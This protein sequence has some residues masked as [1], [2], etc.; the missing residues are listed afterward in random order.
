VPPAD[1]PGGGGGPGRADGGGEVAL[2]ALTAPTPYGPQAVVTRGGLVVQDGT[3]GQKSPSS[4]VDKM[5]STEYTSPESK[6]SGGKPMSS[7]AT[8][9]GPGVHKIPVQTRLDTDDRGQGVIVRKT[10]VT[11]VPKVGTWYRGAVVAAVDKKG[12]T[13]H[14]TTREPTPVEQLAAKAADINAEI[15]SE[16]NRGRAPGKE[17]LDLP[18]LQAKHDLDAAKLRARGASAD[19]VAK[20]GAKRPVAVPRLELARQPAAPWMPAGGFV[21][22]IGAAGDSAIVHSEGYDP[23]TIPLASLR[24]VAAGGSN[25]WVQMSREDAQRGVDHFAGLPSGGAA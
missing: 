22:V 14:V 24:T 9:T 16:Q 13:Y 18:L 21:S 25:P 20:H 6:P 8:S 5:P 19:E 3:G 12:K 4:P 11:E 1:G 17:H 15:Y 7:V 23:Q 10:D 2:P